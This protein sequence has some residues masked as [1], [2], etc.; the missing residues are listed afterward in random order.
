MVAR[1]GPPVL[2]V[3]G[4]TKVY[5][6]RSGDQIAND[7]IDLS[8][9]PGEIVAVLGPNGAGKTTLLRQI[10]GQ[11]LPTSGTIDV[12]GVDMVRRPQAAKEFLSVIPQECTPKEALTVEEHVRYFA[13]L[14]GADPRTIGATVD[15]WLE[16][17]G[18]TDQRRKLIRELSGGLKRRV[19]IAVALAGRSVRLLLLDE[20]TT[21]LDPEARR[22]VWRVIDGLR[23]RQVAILLTTHYIE[24]AEYLADRVL[25]VHHGRFVAA[26]TPEEIRRGLPYGGRLEIRG[27]DYLTAEGRALVGELQGRFRVALR[28]GNVLRLEIPDPFQPAI[29]HELARLTAA[30]VPATLAP[31]SLEDAYL[32]IVGEEGRNGG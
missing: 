27:M 4:L 19:L 15:R 22:A 3:T 9:Q 10:S 26:G 29:V 14:K 5:H 28:A 13:L 11:L 12:G 1:S 17:T 20:P 7:R 23:A 18:L 16:E 24:E 8:I 2:R 31:V 30:G 25:V 32:S 6:G 21:G